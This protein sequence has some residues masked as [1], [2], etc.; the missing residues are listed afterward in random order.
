M[1][2][3]IFIGKWVHNCLPDFQRWSMIQN[4]FKNPRLNKTQFIGPSSIV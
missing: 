4:S 3:F 2:L 1:Y